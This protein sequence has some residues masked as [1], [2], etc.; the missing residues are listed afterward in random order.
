MSVKSRAIFLAVLSD[1][2]L[3]V[4][5]TGAGIFSG[6]VSLLSEAVHSG[7]DMVSS[8]INFLSVRVS[9][10]PPDESHPYGH[11]KFEDM[12][13]LLESILLLFASGSIIYEA[14]IRLKNLKEISM[15]SLGLAVMVFSSLLNLALSFHFS[16]VA[17]KESSIALEAEALD[18]RADII[19]TAGVGVGFILIW[20]FKLY[21]VD[22][23]LAIII[24]LYILRGAVSLFI[25]VVNPLTDS[26][27]S[28]KDIIII[29]EVLNNNSDYIFDY[30]DRGQGG[31]ASPGI[32]IC[33]SRFRII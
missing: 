23:I 30:H 12:S 14:I 4:I 3:I 1:I 2:L 19:S 28:K 6:S 25:K 29:K 15:P 8:I 24:A 9:D 13:G 32:L 11:H 10:K 26:S 31:T 33:T 22:P 18:K 16:N 27:L 20:L 5:K 17:K 7:M 21:Y